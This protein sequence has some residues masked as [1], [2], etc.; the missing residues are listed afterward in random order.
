MKI[1]EH[2]KLLRI[3]RDDSRH[4]QIFA[5]LRYVEKND[6]NTCND[7]RMSIFTC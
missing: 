5:P 3:L 7:F 2:F 1:F 4:E 6:S